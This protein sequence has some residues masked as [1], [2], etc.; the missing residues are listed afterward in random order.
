MPLSHDQIISVVVSNGGWYDKEF[1]DKCY[2]LY[3]FG[4]CHNINWPPGRNAY[5]SKVSSD[6]ETVRETSKIVN[7]L[8][9]DFVNIHNNFNF[10]L[11]CLAASS[12]LDD[13][14]GPTF[15]ERRLGNVGVGIFWRLDNGSM[16]VDS[17]YTAG[18]EPTDNWPS[19]ALAKLSEKFDLPPKMDSG[20]MD[21]KPSELCD[22]TNI[23]EYNARDLDL[24]VWL[25]KNMLMCERLGG[26]RG[27][28]HQCGQEV[29]FEQDSGVHKY[30]PR[31]R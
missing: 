25:P 19:L 5:I 28:G 12:A 18:S 4:V 31:G 21:I 24:H 1:E 9:P 20:T 15:S 13:M 16:I 26:L 2:C 17:M 27:Q 3:T 14:V 10:D 7:M 6:Q 11:R 22:I 23:V 30:H 8:Y 29:G